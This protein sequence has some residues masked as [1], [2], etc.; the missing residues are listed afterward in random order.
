MVTELAL[1]A[2]SSA[3]SVSSVPQ[4]FG[5]AQHESIQAVVKPLSIVYQVTQGDELRLRCNNFLSSKLLPELCDPRVKDSAGAWTA[6]GS[7][8]AIDQATD[9]VRS[10]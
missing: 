6:R 3:F 8:I 2:L 5:L 1:A 4:L 7:I 9:E 10:Q